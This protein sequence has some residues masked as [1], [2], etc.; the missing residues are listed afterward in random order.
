MKFPSYAPEPKWITSSIPLFNNQAVAA[1]GVSQFKECFSAF[2]CVP[3]RS[4]RLRLFQRRGRGGTQR[5][6]EK[7]LKDT[8]Q[9]FVRSGMR[10]SIKLARH[11]CAARISRQNPL[12]CKAKRH[13]SS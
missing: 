1:F 10:L 5:T 6:A 12:S 9:P 8:T 4:L 3:L 13:Q 11:I 7:K 2:L